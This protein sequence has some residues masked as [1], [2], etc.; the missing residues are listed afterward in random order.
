VNGYCFLV[1]NDA[2]AFRDGLTTTN[3]GADDANGA[4]T[5]CFLA[6]NVTV[7]ACVTPTDAAAA[8]DTGGI[9]NADERQLKRCCR[10]TL[11]E[12][13][14]C[15]EIPPAEPSVITCC[16]SDTHT[17]THL[18][19]KTSV[20][21]NVAKGHIGILSTLAVVNAFIRSIQW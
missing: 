14:L 2:A 3:D 17:H 12:K 8:E 4:V 20:Q 7:R 10:G 1:D 15:G 11:G 6:D 19:L 16:Q 5:G 13:S 21:S 9:A 18:S